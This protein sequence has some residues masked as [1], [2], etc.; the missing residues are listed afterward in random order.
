MPSLL[1]IISDVI[2]VYLRF[3]NRPS[4]ISVEPFDLIEILVKLKIILKFLFQFILNCNLL[5]PRYKP[6]FDLKASIMIEHYFGQ[7]RKILAYYTIQLI[8]LQS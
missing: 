7:K 6:Y 8:E 3:S 4:I 2:T 1:L 5:N